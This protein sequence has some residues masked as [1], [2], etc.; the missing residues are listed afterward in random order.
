MH[1]Y[2]RPLSGYSSYKLV[3]IPDVDPTDK[4][5]TLR[6]VSIFSNTYNFFY[7]FSN[8]ITLIFIFLQKFRNLGNKNNKLHELF[9]AAF[10]PLAEDR[11]VGFYNIQ[12]GSII[13]TTSNPIWLALLNAVLGE[14]K[15]NY[16]KEHK[17]NINIYKYIG[18]LTNSKRDEPTQPP[19]FATFE[20]NFK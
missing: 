15:E 2:I 18:T 1:V 7:L 19:H 17:M 13:E 11:S 6:E 9:N 10:E 4:I 12:D 16:G 8:I 3:D 5:S 20:V 14:F